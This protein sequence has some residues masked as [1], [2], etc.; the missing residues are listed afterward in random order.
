MASGVSLSEQAQQNANAFIASL[1]DDVKHIVG[2]SMQALMES[3]IGSQ[4]KNVGDQ[5][6]DFSLP[7]VKG[8][9]S[10]LSDFFETGP[11]VLSFY[12]GGWCPYCNLEFKALQS[13]LEEFKS[14][15]ATL[16]GISPE[17][18]DNSLTT[19]E[20][21]NLQFDV[22]SDVGNYVVK[23]Y[24]LSFIVDES[25]RPLYLKWG[26]NVPEANGDDSYELPIPATYVIDQQGVIRA[27][28]VDKNYINRMD[29]EDIVV[30]LKSIK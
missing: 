1:P 7:N 23:Q 29:P 8:G 6:P 9:L 20:K 18:P 25:M 16:I 27:A 10:A 12:R 14:L 28:H 30:A 22:L 15:G 21:N 19:V 2:S 11:V 5:A 13:R 4:A 17:T 26:I 3:N 24:G